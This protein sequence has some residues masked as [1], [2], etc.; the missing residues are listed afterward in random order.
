MNCYDN[1]KY[2][3]VYFTKYCSK[4][5]SIIYHPKINCKYFKES[6]LSKID[7]FFFPEFKGEKSNNCKE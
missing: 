5:N 2:F 1:C 6:F 7:R 3:R 4:Q